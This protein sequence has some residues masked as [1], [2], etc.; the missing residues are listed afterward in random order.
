M[1][2][3]HTFHFTVYINFCFCC[4]CQ[5]EESARQAHQGVI[6]VSGGFQWTSE[7]PPSANHAISWPDLTRP[8]RQQIKHRLRWLRCVYEA[9]WL[10]YFICGLLLQTVNS[11]SLASSILIRLDI[12]VKRCWS[13]IYSLT[14]YVCVIGCAHACCIRACDRSLW[15]EMEIKLNFLWLFTSVEDQQCF[16]KSG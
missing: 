16:F 6:I 9:N 14:H 15:V 7:W 2:L 8:Y 10:N 3:F 11:T 12:Y 5:K 4:F 13:F 1:D